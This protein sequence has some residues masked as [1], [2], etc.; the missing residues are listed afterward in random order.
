[1]QQ[2]E[3]LGMTGFDL[4]TMGLDASVHGITAASLYNGLGLSKSYVFKN[5]DAEEDRAL[6]DEFMQYLD[7]A[8]ALCAFNGLR[9]DIPFMAKSWDV[10]LER[11][12]GWVLKLTDVFEICKAGI[13]QTFSLAKLLQANNLPCKTGSGLEAIQLAKDKKWKEL[14]DY[15]LED[16]RLTY[17]VTTQRAVVLPVRWGQRTLVLD[18]SN[19]SLFSAW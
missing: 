7:D 1:M 5:E 8:P 4:E 3:L 18:H 15:C 14:G 13:G 6:R 19:P 11:I 12:T 17:L 16:T 10:P 9:F 2:P